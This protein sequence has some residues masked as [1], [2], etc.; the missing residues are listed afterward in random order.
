M[1]LIDFLR[2]PEV[3]EIKN[4][5]EQIDKEK[6]Q[7]FI[8]EN[9]LDKKLR[10][11]Y[12][13]KMYGSLEDFRIAEEILENTLFSGQYINKDDLLEMMK[14]HC[15]NKNREDLFKKMCNLC[16]NGDSIVSFLIKELIY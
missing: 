13:A 10:D 12:W 2:L 7:S 16:P 3:K 4:K 1:E 9:S 8:I 6:R 14:N 11:I 5:I 15:I